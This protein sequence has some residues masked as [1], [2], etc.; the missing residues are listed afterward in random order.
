MGV[1]GTQCAVRRMMVPLALVFGCSES[2]PTP[3]VLLIGLDG[4]RVDILAQANTPNIDALAEAVERVWQ[5]EITDAKSALALL[6]AARKVGL[7][8]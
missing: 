8:S 5:G 7:L 1:R 4:V 2:A 6:L 3:K